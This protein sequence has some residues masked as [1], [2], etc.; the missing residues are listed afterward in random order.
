M[1]RFAGSFLGLLWFAGCAAVGGEL[2]QGTPES[3]GL[4][5]EKL[6]KVD[7]VID[8]MIAKKKL[9][10]AVVM[11]AKDGVVA[12]TGVYGKMDLEADKPMRADAIFRIYSM[13]KA[14]ATAG[15]L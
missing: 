10:G 2:P 9:A 14:I 6:H 15:A 13:T 12:F 1:K 5:S 11:V 4:S 7:G 3:V 8:D